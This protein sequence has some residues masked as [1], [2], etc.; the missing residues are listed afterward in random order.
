M[1]KNNNKNKRRN[2]EDNGKDDVDEEEDEFVIEENKS[3]RANSA[4]IGKK[5]QQKLEFKK[6]NKEMRI[7]RE[8]HEKMKKQ[9]EEL[10]QKKKESQEEMEDE[11]EL[12]LKKLR[13]EIKL[14][15][16]LEYLHW[17]TEMSVTDSGSNLLSVEEQE[18]LA[19]RMIE[20][21]K[22]NKIV[23]LEELVV[24]FSLDMDYLIKCID[25]YESQ[26]RLQG[27]IDEKGKYIYL[28]TEELQQVAN[29]IQS[30][31]RISLEDLNHHIHKI[32]NL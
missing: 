1:R 31:G 24:E 5:K 23:L 32:I 17:K 11:D 3:Y 10:E 20:H 28:S 19:E 18:K 12:L 27:I 15:E 2:Q 14:Q 25:Q 13:E 6:Q 7:A 8:S 30:R 16:E 9:L 4:K 21:I 22:S 26:G 29:V